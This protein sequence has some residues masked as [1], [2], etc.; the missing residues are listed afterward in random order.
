[1]S[2]Y[3]IDLEDFRGEVERLYDEYLMETEHRGI[4]CGEL[5]Y[6]EGLKKKELRELYNELCEQKGE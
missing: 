2:D 3:Y 4:S 1:M 5:V 6:I